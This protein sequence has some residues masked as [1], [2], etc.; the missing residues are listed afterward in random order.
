MF[1]W[2]KIK[3]HTT[4]TRLEACPAKV[5]IGSTGQP[6]NQPKN[7]KLIKNIQETSLWITQIS[8]PTCAFFKKDKTPKIAIEPPIPKTPKAFEGI[9]LNIA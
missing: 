3:T 4:Y 9:A 8:G 5:N 6:P 2:Q 1:S 7:K